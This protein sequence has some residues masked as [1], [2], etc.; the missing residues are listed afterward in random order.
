MLH[1]LRVGIAVCTLF[2]LGACSNSAP[3]VAPR[4]AVALSGQVRAE[5][6]STDPKVFMHSHPGANTQIIATGDNYDYSIHIEIENPLELGAYTYESAIGLSR[7]RGFNVILY[8]CADPRPGCKGIANSTV[9]SL[10]LSRADNV[11]SGGLV[12]ELR[13]FDD[14]DYGIATATFTVP[15]A[16]VVP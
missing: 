13:G 10:T 1:K 2:I 8:D 7:D 4:V 11:I 5:F 12:V 16:Q 14:S 15:P 6:V 3:Q 9:G